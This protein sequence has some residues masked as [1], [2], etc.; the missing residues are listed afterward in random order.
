M[1]ELSPYRTQ[2]GPSAVCFIVI[3]ASHISVFFI[4]CSQVE[5]FQGGKGEGQLHEFWY[6]IRVLTVSLSQISCLS[7]HSISWVWSK[8]CGS[9]GKWNLW[10]G[11]CHLEQL[12]YGRYPLG[13]EM[14]TLNTVFFNAGLTPSW[15]YLRCAGKRQKLLY[16]VIN[17]L[18][19]AWV[20]VQI[21]D[22]NQPLTEGINLEWDNLYPSF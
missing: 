13:Y 15:S 8:I 10:N 3:L 1:E 11:S 17:Y 22:P 9:K 4:A 21:L 16:E 2:P 6:L 7:W 14:L 19:L 20:W 5:V 12:L 18:C